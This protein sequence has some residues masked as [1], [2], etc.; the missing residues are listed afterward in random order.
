MSIAP[1]NLSWHHLGF[2]PDIPYS[3]KCE[4]WAKVGYTPTL[5][6]IPFHQAEAREKFLFGGW[7]A[8]KSYDVSADILPLIVLWHDETR[9][10]EYKG[11]LWLIG[12]DFRQ[13]QQEFRY[14]LK[15]LKMLGW[16][17][18]EPSMPKEGR[19]EMTTVN[20]WLIQTQSSTNIETLGSITINAILVCEAGQHPPDIRDWC[21]GRTME[22]SGPVLYSGTMEE[23]EIWYPEAY[24]KY[25]NLPPNPDVFAMS[26]PSWN[27]PQFKGS[28]NHPEILK[29]KRSLSY[30]QYLL[31]ICGKRAKPSEIVFPEFME[32]PET[33][34]ELNDVDDGEVE[35]SNGPICHVTTVAEY[36]PG[37]AVY[38][39]VDPGEV[40]TVLACHV[41]TLYQK[42]HPRHG[43]KDEQLGVTGILVFDEIYLPHG[44]IES[45]KRLLFDKLWWKDVD[46]SYHDRATNQH[47]NQDSLQEIWMRPVNLG[48]L[49]INVLS[50]MLKIDEGI[51][52]LHRW[53][54]SP[55][56]GQPL[57]YYHP[58]CKNAIKEYSLEKYHKNRSTIK[59][60]LPIDKANH[61]RKA[62]C[63]MINVRWGKHLPYEREKLSES[64]RPIHN[65]NRYSSC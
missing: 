37:Q 57:V 41:V 31:K 36:T 65:W 10:D 29:Q 3:A 2:T 51:Q 34:V 5:L 40:Y 16:I 28:P 12:P 56:T 23:S 18:G 52:M 61:A 22:K 39:A 32:H 55:L 19:W 14:L 17:V 26:L 49:G 30:N 8:A 21:L 6:S 11:V 24:T 35:V 63:Y 4:V 54:V 64:I 47:H 46:V 25:I 7:R 13:A 1:A 59:N 20:G 43:L 53:L 50:Q 60:D 27:N 44:H 45:V 42:P 33:Y 62:L 15:W 9:G 38:L 58:R 48:G